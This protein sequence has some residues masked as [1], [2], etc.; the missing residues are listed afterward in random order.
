VAR[1][2]GRAGD[3]V[4]DASVADLLAL[5]EHL[6]FPAL[7]LKRGMRLHG[8]EAAYGKFLPGATDL[9]LSLLRAALAA[10][11]VRRGGR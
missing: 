10:E 9:Q 6:G 8:G 4:T 7:D 1:G 2:A 5:A 3:A 11:A